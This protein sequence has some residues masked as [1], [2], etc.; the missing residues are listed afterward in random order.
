MAPRPEDRPRSVELPRIGDDVTDEL[1]YAQL[2]PGDIKEP[3]IPRSKG[4]RRGSRRAL[5][6]AGF[7]VAAGALLAAVLVAWPSDPHRQT[8]TASADDDPQTSTTTAPAQAFAAARQPDGWFA[9]TS[10]DDAI[11]LQLPA[12]PKVQTSN[13]Q[14]TAFLVADLGGGSRAEMLWAPIVAGHPRTLAPFLAMTGA[15]ERYPGI[16]GSPMRI[17]DGNALIDGTRTTSKDR[18]NARVTATEH[19]AFIVLLVVPASADPGAEAATWN[20]ILSSLT[21]TA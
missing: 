3:V 9:V 19:F 6:V 7:V 5:V 21:V 1:P 15:M 18:L 13:G 4:A 11:H 14:G 12:E 16:V 20:R 2:V 10:A 8:T 17:V